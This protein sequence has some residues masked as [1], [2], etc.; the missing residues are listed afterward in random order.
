MTRIYIGSINFELTDV[1]MK[2][3]FSQFGLYVKGRSMSIDPAT[4]EH[5][6]FCF[7]EYE[8]P[9]ADWLASDA[10]N[11]LELGKRQ[12]KVGRPNY[13]KNSF[14]TVTCSTR[15]DICCKGERVPIGRRFAEHFG[16]FLENY[17]CVSYDTGVYIQF[18][19]EQVAERA[20]YAIVGTMCNGKVLTRVGLHSKELIAPV[21]GEC[22]RVGLRSHL[23]P[24]LR[25]ER[26]LAKV[27]D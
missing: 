10:T 19:K 26:L 25:Y 27:V 3:V 23:V 6:R 4:D 15:S 13:Y 16:F 21:M 2:H 7:V 9:E 22:R 8:V 5:D 18:A 24:R 12:L 14:K 20:I 17:R 11:G 1:H